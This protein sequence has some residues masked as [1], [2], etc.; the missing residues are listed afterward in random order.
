MGEARLLGRPGKGQRQ[1]PEQ[2]N[3]MKNAGQMRGASRPAFVFGAGEG[4]RT[5]VSSLGS[6]CSTIELHPRAL[7]IND[8]II[9][10]E[11]NGVKG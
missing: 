6:W 8:S 10:R 5:L 1:M 2:K 3:R 9:T 7:H 11:G 4:N